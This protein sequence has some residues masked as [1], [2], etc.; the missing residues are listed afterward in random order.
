VLP[1]IH[2]ASGSES[3]L[4]SAGSRLLILSRSR[5]IVRLKGKGEAGLRRAAQF[6]A[7][8]WFRTG[9][10][11]GWQVWARPGKAVA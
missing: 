6:G 2:I 8:S 5:A 9:R 4:L 11:A 7:V 3:L 1:K 10:I